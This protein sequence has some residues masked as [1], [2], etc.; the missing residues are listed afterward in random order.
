ML[1]NKE[2]AQQ[3]EWCI[4][5]THMEVTKGYDQGR[6]L[7]INGGAACFSG[8]DS[9]LSQVVGWGFATKPKQ[10]RSEIQNIESFYKGLGHTRVDIEICPFVG[11]YLIE[12]LSERGYKV[13]E[14]N[15]VS[16][17]DLKTLSLGT[18]CSVDTIV[19]PVAIDGLAEWAKVVAHGFEYPKARIQF[20]HYAG[21]KGVGVFGAYVNGMLVGGALVAIHGAVCDLGVTSILP[22]FRGRGLQ[23]KLLIA[24]LNYAKEQGLELATV[25]TEP[26][27]ISDLNVQ[28][29]GFHCA[30]T[31]IKMTL[32][33]PA[34]GILKE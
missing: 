5:N 34:G 18:D 8:F 1:I 22:A 12:F 11:N 3:M 19:K 23:K 26:A 17:L 25:T 10:Y 6:I 30:Y 13:S 7:E 27:T 20:A 28:K 21:A 2:T 14:V 15:N 33:D 4:R 16:A 32:G 9:Y 29:V 24:R 31:R